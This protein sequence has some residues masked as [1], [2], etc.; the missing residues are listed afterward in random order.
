MYTHIYIY[1]YI[2]CLFAYLSMYFQL[3]HP[4]VLAAHGVSDA[5]D[6]RRPKMIKQRYNFGKWPGLRALRRRGR[7]VGRLPKMT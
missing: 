4:H 3:L 2:Y 6:V 1:I 7:R 5:L